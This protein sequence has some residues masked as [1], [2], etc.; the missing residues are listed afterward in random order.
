M[1]D[2]NIQPIRPEGEGSQ[3]Q[4]QM[5]SILFGQQAS[6]MLS[7]EQQIKVDAFE[8]GLT[9]ELHPSDSIDEAV[10]KMVR[11]ALAIEFGAVLTRAKG[12]KK[13][14]E[15]IASGIMQDPTLRKQSLLIMDRYAGAEL[16]KTPGAESSEIH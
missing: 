14:I 15:T 12:A 2:K 7:D 10:T 11:M 13:M 16:R 9:Q 6:P 4:S 5:F 1:D 8:K 3:D